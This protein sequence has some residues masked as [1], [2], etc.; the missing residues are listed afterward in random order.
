[1]EKH[2]SNNIFRGCNIFYTHVNYYS[3]EIFGKAFD[4]NFSI[5]NCWNAARNAN[6]ESGLDK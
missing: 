4:V 5:V 3:F 2:K 1:M 6:V